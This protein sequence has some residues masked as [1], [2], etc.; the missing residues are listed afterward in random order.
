MPV[1][2]LTIGEVEQ[3]A[4]AALPPE[5]WDFVSG[6]SDAEVT[7]RAN[8]AAFDRIALTPRVLTGV[9]APDTSARLAG[10]DSTL[11]M[12]VA[13]IAYH[14]LYH[15]DGEL[16]VARAAK[17]LGVPLTVAT[18]SS[19]R[20]EDIAAVGGP[21]WFQLYWLR[22]R[23]QI[24]DLLRRAEALDFRCVMLTVD[25]PPY[26]RRL[27]DVRNG[28]RLPHDV[29]AANLADPHRHVAR[30]GE[31]GAASAIASHT[32]A[33]MHPALSWRDVAWVRENTRLPLVLKGVLDPRDAVLAVEHGADAVV[34]SNHGGRQFDGAPA[35]VAALPAV[36]EAVAG[37]CELLVDGGVRHGT[38]VLKA[39]ALGADGVLLGR[40]VMWG[41]ATDGERGVETVLTILRE[42]FTHALA[43]TGCAGPA[44]ARDLRVTHV[45]E[46]R[47]C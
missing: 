46:D 35:G 31:P 32:D 21:L 2:P 13:P 11:P 1:R 20:L 39:L 15:P 34:V 22:D 9:T 5:T 44:A 33:I 12:A 27:R 6:G 40:P 8:R 42:E 10:T 19:H 14:R 7:L 43:L 41:L 30:A 18:L 29:V 25:C 23:G 47:P 37:R 45:R 38:D 28:F 3:A 36:A 26:G 16:A 24:V 4:E 17:T